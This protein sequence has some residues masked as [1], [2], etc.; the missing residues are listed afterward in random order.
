MLEDTIAAV[1]TPPGAGAIGIVRLSGSEALPIARKLFNGPEP[2]SHRAT[3]GMLKDP[4]SDQPLDQAL[5][6]YMQAP[7]SF[8]GQ[9][10]VELHCHG[11]IHL[12]RT[13][14]QLCL[15]CGARPALAGEFSQ[16]AFLNGKLDL[17]QAEAIMDLIHSRSDPAL[18]QASYQLEGQL[19]APIRSLRQQLLEVLAA[20]E[21]SIDFPDEVDPLAPEQISDL[22][23]Q[24]LLESERLLA[25]HQAGKI[26]RDGLRLALIGRPNAGKSTLL[27]CLLRYERAIVSEIPGTTR[28]TLEDDCYLG[29][30]PVRL[31]DTA[32]IRDSCDPV[33]QIGVERSRKTLQEADLILLVLDASLPLSS[34]DLALLNSLQHRQ[35]VLIWNKIDQ[36]TAR[37][38][39]LVESGWPQVWIS[40]LEKQGLEHL[41]AVIQTE[42]LK[43]QPQDMKVSIND[44]HRLCLNRSREA[45][46]RARET[47]DAGLPD[48]FLAIDLKEALQ[49]FS[50]M[51]G[52]SVSDEVIDHVFHRFCVGK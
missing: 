8:T 46:Q 43:Q 39:S 52:A 12:L 44:R 36:T 34:E 28:D 20:I 27:N 21:A 6:L 47:L 18:F 38:S 29:G 31:I 35:G 42:I 45:L 17:T 32:G 37:P 33:E 3:L 22:I 2:V 1:S 30:I 5:L 25:T 40:A 23:A 9:D 7:R 11:G 14:L 24:A 48:D 49:A 15:T 4:H 50:E 19:S 10:I 41:E 51:I 26:W 13:V 16:R